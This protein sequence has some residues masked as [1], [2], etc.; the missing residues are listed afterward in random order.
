MAPV[1]WWKENSVKGNGGGCRRNLDH[2]RQRL[3]GIGK[4]TDSGLKVND[5]V[6]FLDH[7]GSQDPRAKQRL[8]AQGINLHAVLTLEVI[9]EVLET[10]GRIS[11]QQASELCNSEGQ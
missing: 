7:G 10:A 11:P 3:E 1:D 9:S 4:L 8:H 5:V 6:V 2:R